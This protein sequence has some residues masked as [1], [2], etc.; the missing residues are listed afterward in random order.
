MLPA[1]PAQLAQEP[2]CTMGPKPAPPASPAAVAQ[3]GPGAMLPQAPYM[4]AQPHP[5][6]WTWWPLLQR[7]WPCY[8]QRAG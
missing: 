8:A 7:R 6:I 4:S 3:C 1:R 2:V 5:R